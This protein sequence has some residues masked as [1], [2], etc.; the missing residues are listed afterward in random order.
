[1]IKYVEYTKEQRKSGRVTG[2]TIYVNSTLRCICQ[3][4][5]EAT[6]EARTYSSLSEIEIYSILAWRRR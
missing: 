6:A 5:Y 1:M 2:Y 3:S 4:L